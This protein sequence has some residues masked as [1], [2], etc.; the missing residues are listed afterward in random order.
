MYAPYDPRSLDHH[1]LTGHVVN[2]IKATKS[3]NS[4]IST[5]ILTQT[6]SKTLKTANPEAVTKKKN[7]LI[8]SLYKEE[9]NFYIEALVLDY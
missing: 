8:S 6:I 1:I 9:L 4:I 5:T 3:I 2:A 7:V